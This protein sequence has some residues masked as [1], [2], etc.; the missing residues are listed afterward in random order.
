MYEWKMHTHVPT[1]Y[2]LESK[3][4]LTGSMQHNFAS[5]V[6]FTSNPSRPVTERPKL[7]THQYGGQHTSNRKTRD[8]NQNLALAKSR[9]DVGPAATVVAMAAREGDTTFPPFFAGEASDTWGIAVDVATGTL[10]TPSRGGST[11]CPGTTANRDVTCTSSSTSLH[12]WHT[13]PVK[14]ERVLAVVA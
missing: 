13:R 4:Y 11:A 9:T 6:Q 8:E 1:Q 14:V 12:T 5:N 10:A 3:L 2:T 7:Q